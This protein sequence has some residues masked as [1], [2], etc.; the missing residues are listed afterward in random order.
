MD[1]LIE[2]MS[3]PFD[4]PSKDE[5][6]KT[7]S[8]I[9]KE[10][11]CNYCIKCNGKVY[12]FAEIEFYYWDKERWNEKWNR[13]TYPRDG[14]EAGA[15]FF[16]LSGFDICFKS[17]YGEAKFGGILIRSI[18]DEKNEV[19]SGPLTCK[20]IVLNSCGTGEMPMLKNIENIEKKREWTPAVKSTNRLLGKEDMNNNIDGNL[21]LC[22]YDSKIPIDNWNQRKKSFDKDRGCE[23]ERKGSYNVNRFSK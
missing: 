10:L 23:I 16:H 18:M 17:S 15:L 6:Q 9:A 5:F 8:D 11:F 4:N 13:V 19:I 21:N 1:K 7:C 22:F 20:D 12:Y 3:N 14:Y 2:K